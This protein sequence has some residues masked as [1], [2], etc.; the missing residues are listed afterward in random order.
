MLVFNEKI[1]FGFFRLLK[2]TSTKPSNT[3]VRNRYKSSALFSYFRAG[4]GGRGS[5]YGYFN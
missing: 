3:M 5:R 2:L 4:K 1:N